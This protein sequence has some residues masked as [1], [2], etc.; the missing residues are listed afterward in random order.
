MLQWLSKNR[1][2][3]T[4]T[5]LGAFLVAVFLFSSPVFAQSIADQ[6]SQLNQGVQVIQ[7][8]LG[9]P[10]LDI[11][12]IV[13]NIIKWLLGLVGL[14]LV[15]IIMYAGFLWMTAA[16][17]EDQITQAKSTMRNAVI[18]LAI[19]LSAYS[20]VLFVLNML[21]VGNGVDGDGNL[22]PPVVEN[23]AGSS[24]LGKVVKDHYPT[25][26]QKEVPRNSKI[27]ISFFKPI[28]PSSFIED[29]NANGIYGD[30]VVPDN[31]PANTP[32]NWNTYC[33]HVTS[34]A[35]V[36]SNNFINL[37]NTKTGQSVS[38]LVALTSSSTVNGVSGIFTLVLKPITDTTTPDGGVLGSAT[39]NISY[40]VYL[41]NGIKTD[42]PAGEH[43]SI[44]PS[45][46]PNADHY[47]WNFTCSNLLDITPPH[48]V[49]FYPNSTK[50][51]PRNTVIQVSFDKPVN[52]VGLQGDFLNSSSEFL[53]NSDRSKN[54]IFATNTYGMLPAG[55]WNLVNN[56]QTLEFTPSESC[57]R[58]ACGDTIYCLP[59]C[60]SSNPS[61]Q[62][63]NYKLL[64]KTA[65]TMANSGADFT[66]IPFTGVD[67]LSGNALDGNQDMQRQTPTNTLPIFD[68]W[69]TPD[70]KG[71]NF[72][73]ENTIDKVSPYLEHIE[74]G[75][76]ASDVSPDAPWV[77]RFSKAMRVGSVYG[78]DINEF[79]LSTNGVGLWKVP[80]VSSPDFQ[81]VTMSHG[82]FLKVI[83]KMYMPYITS[84]VQDTHF[85]CFYP[86]LGPKVPSPVNTNCNPTV[87]GSCC[88]VDGNSNSSNFCCNGAATSS[89]S[90]IAG[91]QQYNA[92]SYITQ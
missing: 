92:S 7:E 69:M 53:L 58:N 12:T 31:T 17:N 59:T 37:T 78:I 77:M 83:N 25:R 42:D 64:F 26:D 87:T 1:F 85:N 32:Y 45:S 20:I 49:S 46:N 62:S 65:A 28:L 30:C 50:S 60:P 54:S 6:N 51:Q 72:T 33:D 3:K 2:L 9:L 10:G 68:N 34:T 57:G 39:E 89:A 79:P 91:C 43:P 56:F 80:S 15:V 63:A 16:G 52:P 86:G 82:S 73:I 23:L 35:G 19:I 36:L 88:A 13:A 24:A 40:T 61:C 81:T 67:D 55:S 75:I 18:G 47:N 5:I 74:P 29:T 22:N 41:G 38:G 48:I 14:I 44:F 21:G 84:D 8:P 90:G 4:A 71:W 66:D 76:T 27:V 70:N 11:R